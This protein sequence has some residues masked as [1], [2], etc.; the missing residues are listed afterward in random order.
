MNYLRNYGSFNLHG[1]V[2]GFKTPPLLLT[3]FFASKKTGLFLPNK[4]LV[5]ASGGIEKPRFS[6]AGGLALKLFM[7]EK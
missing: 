1:C 6:W 5:I 3:R 2:P 7:F 4:K